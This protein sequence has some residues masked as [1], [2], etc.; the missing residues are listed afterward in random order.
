MK[1]TRYFDEQVLRKRPYIDL[2]WCAHVVLNPLHREEQ[3][4][5]QSDGRVRFWGEVT[6]MGENSPRIPPVVTLEDGQTVHNA[7]LDR[8]FRRRT[9]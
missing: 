8:S 5:E 4:E 1:T 6:M 3:S 9:P 7:F 2:A